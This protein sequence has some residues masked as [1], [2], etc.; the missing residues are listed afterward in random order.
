[1]QIFPL[2]FGVLPG[3]IAFYGANIWDTDFFYSTVVKVR[4]RIF[5]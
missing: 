5:S 2:P 3:E 4:A 1:V